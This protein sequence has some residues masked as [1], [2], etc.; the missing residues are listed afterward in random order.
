MADDEADDGP[1]GDLGSQL[2][3][4]LTA[5]PEPA[6]TPEPEPAPTPVAETPEPTPAVTPEPTPEP[7]VEDSRHKF[8][9]ITG[10]DVASKY[11]S[12]DEFLASV[13]ELQKVLG[14]RN[15]EAELGRWVRENP[16]EALKLL[17]EQ[18]GAKEAKAVVAQAQAAPEAKSDQPP[19]YDPNW[20]YMVEMDEATGQLKSKAGFPPEIADKFTKAS[21]WIEQRQREVLFNPDKLLEP[22]LEKI[23]EEAKQAALEEF[24]KEFAQRDAQSYQGYVQNHLNTL[25]SKDESLLLNQGQLTPLGQAYASEIEDIRALTVSTGKQLT[26][27]DVERIHQKAMKLA[28]AQVA[29]HAPQPITPVPAAAKRVQAKPEVAPTSDDD[30]WPEG[31]SLTDVLNKLG[32]AGQLYAD[33]R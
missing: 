14:R 19:E 5:T 9:K 18:Y 12:E 23:K 16:Q 32:T 8:Q 20:R 17:T 33:R 6:V 10:Y 26:I 28:V 4:T 7:T 3:E 29:G 31:T 30:D 1:I 15:D 25:I 21:Q 2:A 24:R 11:K 13:G 27:Q 22:R